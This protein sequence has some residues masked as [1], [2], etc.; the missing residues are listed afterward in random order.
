MAHY[1]PEMNLVP[2]QTIQVQATCAV[3][4]PVFKIKFL[5]IKIP[6]YSWYPPL[7]NA[8]TKCL[9]FIKISLTIVYFFKIWNHFD[10]FDPKSAAFY[11]L[12]TFMIRISSQKLLF[13]K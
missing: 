4:V 10:F 13:D 9:Y 11:D 12:R 7:K 3:P 2:N 1:A 5:K 8:C 6:V